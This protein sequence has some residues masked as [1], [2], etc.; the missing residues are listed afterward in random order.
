M[1]N[2]HVRAV[3]LLYPFG[4]LSKHPYLVSTKEA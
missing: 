1:Y 2:R 4:D 3:F